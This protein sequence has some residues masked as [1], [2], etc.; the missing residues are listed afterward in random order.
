M[1]FHISNI[2]T[3]RIIPV[4]IVSKQ[5]LK[6]ELRSVDSFIVLREKKHW[7]D[8]MGE[9]QWEIQNKQPLIQRELEQKGF[10]LRFQIFIHH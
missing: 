5:A 7:I 4:V 9:D 2:F 10:C 1:N 8:Q 3:S 6:T